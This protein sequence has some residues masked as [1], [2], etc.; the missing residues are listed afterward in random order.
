VNMILISVGADTLGA[1]CG[2][3]GTLITIRLEMEAKRHDK[4]YV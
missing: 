4:T 2:R 1:I 3:V